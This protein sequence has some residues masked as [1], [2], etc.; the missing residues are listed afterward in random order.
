MPLGIWISSSVEKLGQR[1][2]FEASNIKTSVKGMSR[3][4]YQG[5]VEVR[6]WPMIELQTVFKCHIKDNVPTYVRLMRSYQE[7]RAEPGEID[8]LE[9]RATMNWKNRKCSTL[10]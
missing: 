1:R 3:R 8:F 7:I 10:S 6:R 9:V 2:H 4:G 5:K